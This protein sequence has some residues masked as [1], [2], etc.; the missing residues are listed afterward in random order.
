MMVEKP[1]CFAFTGGP[2]AGKTT[3]LTHLEARGISVAPDSARAV[4]QAEGGRPE[5]ERFCRL[6]LSRDVE[7]F[8]D[9]SGLTLFDR[10]LVDAWGMA[11]VYGLALPEAATAVRDLRLNRVAF[12]A[13][14]W[15]QIYRVDAE[16]DQ[17]WPQ[18]VFAY[19]ASV[20]AYQDAGYELIELPL[21]EVVQRAEFVLERVEAALGGEG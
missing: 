16:R 6:V 14:P 2:G 12:V 1:E 5:P 3:L 10:S 15:R 13:P 17:T 18:A 20:R 11:S 4:I 21:V 9:A 8:H 7:A 19:E